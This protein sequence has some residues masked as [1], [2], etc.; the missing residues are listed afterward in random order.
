MIMHG[1]CIQEMQ[2][3]EP[4]SISCIV[5]DPPY[6]L[7][8]MG[9]GWDHAV[10]GKE[11]WVEALRVIKP[12]GHLLA[13]GGARTYHR[14]VC[15][16]EDAGFEI[17]DQIQWIYAQG[18]P[19]S[20]N[21]G[22]KCTGDPIPYNHE[23][24]TESDSESYLRSMPKADLSSSIPIV[25]PEDETVFPSLQKQS[26]QECGVKTGDGDEIRK[27][28]GMERG[29]DIQEEQ[30]KLHRA[31][32]CEMSDR[33]SG[34]GEE[35]R[36][37]H[38]ASSSDG[39]AFESDITQ[40][41]GCA[42]SRSQYSK[43]QYRKS[44]IIPRQSNSQNCGMGSCEVCGGLIGF[45]GYGTA[46]KPAHE[47]IVVAMKKCQGTFKQNAGTWGQA[48]INIDG[49]RIKT[50]DNIKEDSNPN[51]RH[52]KF[53]T[54]YE[55]RNTEN[56]IPSEHGRWPAN[57]ILD[58]EAGKILDE[59]RGIG[60]SNGNSRTTSSD[61]YSGG[62]KAVSREYSH[63]NDKGGASRFFY[64][65]KA[66]SSERS[67]GLDDLPD[68]IGGGMCSTVSGDSRTGAI[69]VQKNNHP[70]VKPLKLM[71]YLVKLVMPPK[72][73]ILLDPFAGSGTTILAAKRLGFNAIGI[74][75]E[76]EYCKI[77]RERVGYI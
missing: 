10:P 18:F 65:A 21:F 75:K 2:K 35:G 7:S 47:P 32:V 50:K 5:T 66:S 61:C 56:Y 59:Q 70:T 20:H 3:M 77:A 41:G 9:K 16:I 26:L 48:G 64:C 19:K 14:M 60:R 28:S 38:G 23:K 63:L 54:Q 11:Y 44:R 40:N 52:R 73:G 51:I 6:G 22:C 31:E 13:F 74:E 49:C 25:S 15:A 62:F 45:E 55:V 39:Q 17:R 33:T 29:S 36:L 68:Q 27:E 46:L 37:Y 4:N 69:T 1:D 53:N 72:D 34:N 43:Q 12:G 58:E 24:T 8:F 42:S 67:E 71:E 57:V 76:E 30:G